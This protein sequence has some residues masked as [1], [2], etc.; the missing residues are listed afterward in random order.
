V[1]ISVADDDPH[2][3][4]FVERLLAK[5]VPEAKVDLFVQPADA[6][7]HIHSV[8]TDLLITDHGMGPMNGTDLIRELRKE[9]RTLPII[10]ISHSPGVR[11][12][13]IA[14]GANEFLDKNHVATQLPHLV[15]SYLALTAEK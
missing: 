8:S 10:M 7:H 14:A 15:R 2:M 5:E 11:E 6:L 13:A 12:E 1:H 4:F 3:L 9:H